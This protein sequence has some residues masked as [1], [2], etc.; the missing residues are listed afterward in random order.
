MIHSP[1]SDYEAP[2]TLVSGHR[3]TSFYNT[4]LDMLNKK[5]V[6]QKIVATPSLHSG[7]NS[8]VGVNTFMLLQELS[9]GLEAMCARLSVGKSN[10][11]RIGEFLRVYHLP[12]CI[13]TLVHVMYGDPTS[14]DGIN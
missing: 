14:G 2:G 6:E 10:L 5:Y 7:D 9:R 3:L 12:A 13:A 1:T 8:I 11:S 4:V